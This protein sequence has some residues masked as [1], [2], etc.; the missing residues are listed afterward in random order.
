VGCFI[1]AP[2]RNI[3]GRSS[4]IH[5]REFKEIRHREFRE[6]SHREFAEIR[7]EVTRSTMGNA[8]NFSRIF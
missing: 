5:H 6:M 3:T 7:E 8:Q 4:E 1:R 2:S